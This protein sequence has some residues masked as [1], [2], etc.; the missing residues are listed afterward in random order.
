[1]LGE[2]RGFSAVRHLG[3]SIPEFREFIESKFLN[4]MS[5]SNYGEWH[6]DHIVPLARFD[7]SKDDQVMIACNY[8]NIQPLWAEDNMKK[9]SK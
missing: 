3:I 4:G 6:L 2:T 9:G 1:M 7:L 8:K 5:W